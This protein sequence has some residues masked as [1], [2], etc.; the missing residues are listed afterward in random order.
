MFCAKC[1]KEMDDN[2]KFCPSC[3]ADTS[4]ET[5][6]K[7]P[8]QQVPYSEPAA[9]FE[10]PSEPSSGI[11]IGALICGIIGLVLCWVPIVGLILSIV[12][13]V[14]GG[15]GR[16]TLPDGKRG[17]ALAGF[18]LGII[19]LVISII[20]LISWIVAIAL[21]GSVATWALGSML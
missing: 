10:Q 16:K 19:G 3:G 2:A 11:G 9:T 15:K 13:V 4:G 6:S 20:V 17:M 21:I 12:A 7:Q 8:A 14:L 5:M 1:G 18:I